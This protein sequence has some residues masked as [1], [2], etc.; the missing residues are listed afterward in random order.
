MLHTALDVMSLRPE[1]FQQGLDALCHFAADAFHSPIV[2]VTFMEANVHVFQ[3]AVGVRS[4]PC[5]PRA[6][7]LCNVAI[8]SKHLNVYVDLAAAPTKYATNS[9]VLAH[10]VQFYAG[11][12]I[13]VNDAAIGTV[14]L[15]GP[16]P[17]RQWSDM[18]TDL[19][20][21]LARLVAAEL[22]NIPPMGRVPRRNCATPREMLLL[23]G[24]ETENH[25]AHAR[26]L[27]QARTSA[28]LSPR[29]HSFSSASSLMLDPRDWV[30]NHARSGCRVCRRKFSFPFRRK[31]HCRMCGEVVCNGCSRLR[32]FVL[33]LQ[34][35]SVQ[36][37]I[38]SE[39][40][41]SRPPDV[42]TFSPNIR[43]VHASPTADD[44]LV[45]ARDDALLSMC[46]KQ[47]ASTMYHNSLEVEKLARAFA[48][49]VY[50]PTAYLTPASDAMGMWMTLPTPEA[51]RTIQH[52]LSD[53]LFLEH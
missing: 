6:D 39:C 43:L 3:A 52:L 30:P 22:L 12:P 37:R 15:M 9:F 51:R 53:L 21:L 4:L 28:M 42:P 50:A 18:E 13:L 11:A 17:R 27:S 35:H 23:R 36:I 44:Y 14:C 8:T 24:S 49:L 47:R 1:A 2:A 20:L 41:V 38:C 29:P 7:A 26:T 16:S 32:P 40:H 10:G 45:F 48:E 46:P 34:S 31:H 19:L 25:T 5:L 33:P